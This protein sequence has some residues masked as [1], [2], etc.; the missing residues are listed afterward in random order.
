V[1]TAPAG[2]AASAYNRPQVK[3]ML[4]DALELRIHAMLASGRE[5]RQA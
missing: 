3:M 5:V 4:L 2:Q 1:C